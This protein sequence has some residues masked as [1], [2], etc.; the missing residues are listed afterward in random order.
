MTDEAAAMRV[1][2]LGGGD[3]GGRLRPT[4][5]WVAP[6]FAAFAAGTVPWVV[7]LAYSLPKTVRVHD[8][9]AWVG[10]DI[11]LILVFATTAYLAWR[12]RPWVVLTATAT[13]TM[14]VV[15]AWFDLLTSKGVELAVAVG[16]AVVELSLAGVC[17]WIA[18]HAGT[19]IRH[20]LAALARRHPD[21]APGPEP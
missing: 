5:R 13:A 3:Q 10:F 11:L 18:L 20:R 2:A 16:T 15:D 12:G 1:A 17:V 6:L 21:P 4:P 9:T 19:I 14:L 7:Y 8:R